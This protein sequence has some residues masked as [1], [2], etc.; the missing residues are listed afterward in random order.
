[1][2]RGGRRRRR[3]VVEAG[4]VLGR[5]TVDMDRSRKQ[6]RKSGLAELNSFS[7]FSERKT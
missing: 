6:R 4:E 2:D 7:K 5:R 3:R 1:M